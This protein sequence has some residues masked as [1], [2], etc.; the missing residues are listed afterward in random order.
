MG[1]VQVHAA[2]GAQVASQLITIPPPLFRS[3]QGEVAAHLL[4]AHSSRLLLPSAVRTSASSPGSGGGWVIGDQAGLVESKDA[5]V[6]RPGAVEVA[7]LTKTHPGALLSCEK[8]TG[9]G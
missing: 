8:M 1:N 7:L 2:V 9:R 6:Q 4:P 5:G 3:S